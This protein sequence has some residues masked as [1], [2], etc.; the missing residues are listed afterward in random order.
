MKFWQKISLST[1]VVFELFFVPASIY[2]INSNFTST[3]AITVDNGIS[4]QQRFCSSLESNLFLLKIQRGTN[5]YRTEVDK[6]SIDAM[7]ARYANNLGDTDIFL[8]AIDEQNKVI[9]SS[10]KVPLP[11]NRDELHTISDKVSYIIRDIRGGMIF[12]P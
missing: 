8:E 4:E 5:S 9:Y 2:L 6:Q 11:T 3:L 12:Y 10:L 7:I 1:L